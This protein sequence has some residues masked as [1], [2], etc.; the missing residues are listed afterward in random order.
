MRAQEFAL[1][2]LQFIADRPEVPLAGNYI[3]YLRGHGGMKACKAFNGYTTA[4]RNDLGVLVQWNE[5][6]PD[7]GVQTTYTGQVIGSYL[8]AGVSSFALFRHH[9][10]TGS[11][12]NR[13]DLAIDVYDTG[14]DIEETLYKALKDGTATTRCKPHMDVSPD[15]GVTLY[16]GSRKSDKCLRIYDKAK[17]RGIEGDWKRVELELSGDFAKALGKELRA[18]T[19]EQ[20]K[21]RAK[22]LIAGV[23][24]FHS[25]WWQWVVGNHPC[26]LTVPSKRADKIQEWI[27]KQV[28]PALATYIKNGGNR[29]VI[30]IL[31][32]LVDIRLNE[33]T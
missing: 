30:E 32:E 3:Y 7:M 2:W 18:M 25:E 15:G 26:R 6:R 14:I 33:Q 8:I 27:E 5:N 22:D 21:Q 13:I 17:E 16:I 24:D 23:V 11:R 10:A 19:D 20:I 4:Y 28:A 9:L 31:R 12:V 1:D 29:N